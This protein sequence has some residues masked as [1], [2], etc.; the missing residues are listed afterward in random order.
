MFTYPK[1]YIV[2]QNASLNNKPLPTNINIGDFPFFTESRND[3]KKITFKSMIAFKVAFYEIATPT[4]ALK[5]DGTFSGILCNDVTDLYTI[6]NDYNNPNEGSY[7]DHYVNYATVTLPYDNTT[8]VLTILFAFPDANNPLKINYTFTRDSGNILEDYQKHYIDKLYNKNLPDINLLLAAIVNSNDFDSRELI[9]KLLLDQYQIFHN[10]GTKASIENFFKFLG[11][12]NFSDKRLIIDDILKFIDGENYKTGYYKAEYN[13][14][15]FIENEP[16]YDE[17]NLPN[18]EIDN[19]DITE[20]RNRASNAIIL[21]NKYF[22]TEEQLINYFTIV[23]STN[24]PY[25]ESRQQRN[26]YHSF[27]DTEYFRNDIRINLYQYIVPDHQTIN[28]DKIVKNN[29][30]VN[31]DD[32]LEDIVH[33]PISKVLG[34]FTRYMY[35]DELL[36]TTLYPYQTYPYFFRIEKE[37]TLS[38]IDNFYNELNHLIENNEPLGDYQ[39]MVI[40][41]CV[42]RVLHLVI[43]IPVCDTDTSIIRYVEYKF[44][45]ENDDRTTPENRIIYYEKQLYTKVIYDTILLMKHG[46]YRLEVQIYDNYGAKDKWFYIINFDSSDVIIDVDFYNSARSVIVGDNNSQLTNEPSE[47]NILNEAPNS[48]YP[49][50]YVPVQRLANT[51]LPNQLNTYYDAPILVTDISNYFDHNLIPKPI[52]ELYNHHIPLGLSTQSLPLGLG[53]PYIHVITCAYST[54]SFNYPIQFVNFPLTNFAIFYKNPLTHQFEKN[55]GSGNSFHSIDFD[56]YASLIPIEET[57]GIYQYKETPQSTPIAVN[58]YMM[59]ISTRPGQD[60]ITDNLYISYWVD[61]STKVFCPIK[62]CPTYS[63]IRLPLNYNILLWNSIKDKIVNY[64]ITDKDCQIFSTNTASSDNIDKNI[65]HTIEINI[66]GS[67]V[68]VPILYSTY[69]SLHKY[70]THADYTLK[71]ND[72][73]FFKINSEY[74]NKPYE[75]VMEI[76]D[77]FNNTEIIKTTSD[78]MHT[79]KNLSYRCLR[80]GIFD[81]IVRCKVNDINGET[82]YAHRYQSLFNV[83]D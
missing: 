21:A 79:M 28:I 48:E 51:N 14:T 57:N 54:I 26:Q 50:N 10:K 53:D 63:E 65:I 70:E 83:V 42:S 61:S 27:Y 49:L 64:T 38:D 76:C 8:L 18:T 80:N 13:I 24:I 46:R 75:I 74:I 19:D 37:M 17:Y 77:T 20:F 62:N 72:I 43:H 66:G 9:K 39:H 60:I 1:L 3:V 71:K 56:Y 6:Y 5:A 29:Y 40:D 12:E 32:E 2:N 36:N 58:I 23:Y 35:N 31:R 30:V 47:N 81:L 4:M 25:I 67:T 33:N 15:D 22:T 69:Y 41:G 45:Y 52:L 55:D 44:Y 73:V 11:Y 59:L 68:T 78:V 34:V 16:Q 7:I 82:E